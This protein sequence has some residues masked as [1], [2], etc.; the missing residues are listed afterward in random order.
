M[1]GK[2]RKKLKASKGGG[3]VSGLIIQ[4]GIPTALSSPE[5]QSAEPVI[6]MAVRPAGGRIFAEP[7]KKKTAKPV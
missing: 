4:E 2:I 1:S 5:G 6:Y 7:S 3:A